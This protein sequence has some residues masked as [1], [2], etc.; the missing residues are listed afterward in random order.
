M[1]STIVMWIV[2]LTLFGVATYMIAMLVRSIVK[3]RRRSRIRRIWGNFALSLAFATLFLLSWIVQG[4]AEWDV[5]RQDQ[6]AHGEPV[7][8]SD[9]VVRFGQSTLENW[10][11]EFLQLFSFVVLSAVFIHRGSGESKDG[12][13]RIET[14]VNEIHRLLVE[15][16]GSGHQGAEA[17]G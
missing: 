8:V 11:S 14:T 4:I 5:Y 13:D 15:G 6:Q 1:G 7:A 12:Q 10:Q 3:E 16:N 17:R 2:L 9:Y